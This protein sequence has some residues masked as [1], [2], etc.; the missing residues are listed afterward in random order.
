MDITIN[1][2]YFKAIR[3]LKQTHK[4]VTHHNFLLV[5]ICRQLQT[6]KGFFDY[7]DLLRITNEHRP[8]IRANFMKIL[9]DNGVF[10][11]ARQHKTSYR[12]RFGRNGHYL[13]NR[14]ISLI[15]V[16]QSRDIVF[17]D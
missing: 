8:N 13:Y 11:K 15:D 7:A 5:L 17:Y 4:W 14:Y 1:E 10:V 3:E 12:Y 6:E 9:L 2:Y 16:Y